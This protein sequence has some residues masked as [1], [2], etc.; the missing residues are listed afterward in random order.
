MA[1]ISYLILTFLI[2]ACAFLIQLIILIKHHQEM[3]EKQYQLAVQQTSPL[4]T[5]AEV[6]QDILKQ[7]DAQ[8]MSAFA[9]HEELLSSIQNHQE[10][11]H[12]LAVQQT[13]QLST[14]VQLDQERGEQLAAQQMAAS[15]FHKELLSSIQ[16]HQEMQ[17]KQYQLTVQQISQLS[18]LTQVQQDILKQL[19]AQQMSAL[20]FHKDLLSSIQNQQ[21]IQEKQYRRLVH[22]SCVLH[23]QLYDCSTS[24]VSGQYTISPSNRAL[25]EFKVYCD[26]DTTPGGWTLFQRKFDGSVN[27][28]RN[29]AEYEDGFGSLEGEFWL[30]LKKLHIL[31]SHNRWELRVDL[32]DF[33]GNHAYALYDEFKAGDSSSLYR[34]TIGSYSGTAGNSMR[35]GVSDAN[36]MAFTTKDQD[37]DH[38]SKGNCG[39]DSRRGGWWH[40][41]CSWANLNGQYLG[42]NGKSRTGMFWHEWKGL[43][44]LKKS[45][46]KIRTTG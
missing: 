26:M 25:G 23:N 13:S 32:E 39:A 6:Q 46:M 7:L 19:T 24:L 21:E 9:C 30:G 17:E 12:Q 20:A 8:Q 36:G 14:L 38:W 33:E 40:R 4:S 5:L 28:D 34:L 37:N 22:I 41:Y 44:S 1:T 29:W 3:Q 11:Q 2:L 16:N 43:L 45:E 18:T 27:F 10:K 15:A 31:T 35:Y 42:Q